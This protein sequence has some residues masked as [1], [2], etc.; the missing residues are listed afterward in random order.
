MPDIPLLVLS[1]DAGETTDAM[2]L[3][4]SKMQDELASLSPGSQHIVVQGSRHMIQ[5]DLPQ[6]VIDAINWMITELAKPEGPSLK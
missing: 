3:A 5:E 1:H 2:N 4:W 6:A